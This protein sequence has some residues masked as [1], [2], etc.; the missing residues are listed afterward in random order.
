MSEDTEDR[1]RNGGKQYPPKS[2]KNS[3]NHYD[4]KPS[5]EKDSGFSRRDDESGPKRSN[6]NYR[7]QQNRHNSGQ[8][9]QHK[10][11]GTT[12][13]KRWSEHQAN[14]RRRKKEVYNKISR[15]DILDRYEMSSPPHKEFMEIIEANLQIFV[16]EP[17]M[18]INIEFDDF[19]VDPDECINSK[20]N[21]TP[22]TQTSNNTQEGQD[23]EKG[24]KGFVEWDS[25]ES[26]D[27]FNDFG[28]KPSFDNLTHNYFRY[29][30][31]GC[32]ATREKAVNAQ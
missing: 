4:S 14:P 21:Y 12:S 26:N 11:I 1:K 22:S 6:D 32:R 5:D 31:K 24:K 2:G 8:N 28:K 17:L 19:D 18:P 10:N 16:K 27:I 7:G 3:K 13:Y 29:A 20:P 23:V 25:G 9:Y 30:K 15:D